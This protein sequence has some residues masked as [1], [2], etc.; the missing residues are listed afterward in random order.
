MGKTYLS[1]LAALMCA[2]GMSAENGEY[3]KVQ[4]TEPGTLATLMGDKAN[5]IDSLVVRA[6]SM[7]RISSRCGA[8][9]TMADSR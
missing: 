5:E 6:L 2:V 4:V 7:K 8:R 1:L 9:H 3:L